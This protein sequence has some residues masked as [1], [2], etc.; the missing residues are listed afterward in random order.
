MQI[1][2]RRI[3]GSIVVLGALVL[4]LT[5]SCGGDDEDPTA[6]PTEATSEVTATA[7]PSDGDDDVTESAGQVTIGDDT[8]EL[9]PRQCDVFPGGIVS[10][11]G[12]AIGDPD[13][14]IV[15]DVFEADKE[16]LSVSSSDAN[17]SALSD[18]I[19]VQVD[20][21]RVS[22]TATVV[23]AIGES[24]DATFEFNCN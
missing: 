19:D 7:A 20:D 13:V 5:A 14:E 3:A 21:R 6:V 17:W 10:V 24:A 18:A 9:D 1:T 22:G 23:T 8:W 4:A 11:S 2:N 12:F 15:F 16:N